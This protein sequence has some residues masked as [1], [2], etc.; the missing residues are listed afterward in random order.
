MHND[1]RTHD[2]KVCAR[3][4]TSSTIFFAL[5]ALSLLIAGSVI[6]AQNEECCSSD[7][8]KYCCRF[9]S[10]PVDRKINVAME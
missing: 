10:T 6:L 5:A 4:V 3:C 9:V 1:E 2:K 8:E 7:T